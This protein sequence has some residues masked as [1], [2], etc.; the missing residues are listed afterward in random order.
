MTMYNQPIATKQ[1]EIDNLISVIRAR[2]L[3][4]QT[5]F[6]IGRDLGRKYSQDK[7]YLAYVA[8]TMLNEA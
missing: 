3:F 6:E 5:K 2:L 4:G 8:A 7:I 1:D